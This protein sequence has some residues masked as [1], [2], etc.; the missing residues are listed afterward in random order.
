[1]AQWRDTTLSDRANKLCPAQLI[2]QM[3][4]FSD[5]SDILT[6]NKQNLMVTWFVSNSSIKGDY[7]INFTNLHHESQL[8]FVMFRGRARG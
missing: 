6:S 7:R 1:M 3:C 2:V 5:E 8:I 4:K